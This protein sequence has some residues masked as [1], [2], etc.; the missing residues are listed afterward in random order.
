MKKTLRYFT[1]CVVGTL[2]LD[3]HP[4]HVRYGLKE[5]DFVLGERSPLPCM[6]AQDTIRTLAGGYDDAHAAYHVVL[7]K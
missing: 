2:A 4:E 3:H 6:C 1:T 5:I 7:V